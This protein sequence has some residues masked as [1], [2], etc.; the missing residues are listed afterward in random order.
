M[1]QAII[2]PQSTVICI[3]GILA[4]VVHE[5]VQMKDCTQRPLVT[6]SIADGPPKAFLPIAFWNPSPGTV[7]IFE[8]LLHQAVNVTKIRVIADQERGN[9]YESIGNH[10]KVT[11]CKNPTLET[12]WFKPQPKPTADAD[13]P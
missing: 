9:R 10:S 5:M 3:H 4:K 13:Q 2:V 11:S 7:E 8:Q 12:W 1:T 6:I